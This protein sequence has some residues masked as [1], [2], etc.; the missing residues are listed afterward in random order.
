MSNCNPKNAHPV[1][2]MEHKPSLLNQELNET[3][4]EDI[5]TAPETKG[6]NNKYI[7]IRE[8]PNFLAWFGEWTTPETYEAMRNDID[9][10]GLFNEQGEPK[11][12]TDISGNK[13]LLNKDGVKMPL[14][15]LFDTVTSSEIN[16]VVNSLSGEYIK[17]LTTAGDT[18]PNLQKYANKKLQ[19]TIPLLE[20][21]I[22]NAEADVMDGVHD[23][24]TGIIILDNFER[25]LKKV[26]LLLSDKD[27]NANLIKRMRGNLEKY[28]FRYSEEDTVKE[29]YTDDLDNKEDSPEDHDD[30]VNF[31]TDSTQVSNRAVDDPKILA[32]LS[33]IPEFKEY[34]A[35]PDNQKMERNSMLSTPKYNDQ[36]SMWGLIE[37]YLV[38]IIPARHNTDT[39]S[40]DIYDT[41]VRVLEENAALTKHPELNY[42]A[43]KLKTMEDVYGKDYANSFKIKFA[44]AFYKSTQN[45]IITQ[46]AAEKSYTPGT[47]DTIK[48]KIIDPAVTNSKGAKITNEYISTILNSPKYKDTP[49][50]LEAAKKPLVH[51]LA[52]LEKASVG[53]GIEN[54]EY[55]DLLDQI[56]N[57]A[58]DLN[59][60]MEVLKYYVG[61]Y[62]NAEPN[63]IQ[64]QLHRFLKRPI[65]HANIL[66]HASGVKLKG[67]YE[68]LEEIAYVRYKDDSEESN[69]ILRARLLESG[70]LL[71]RMAEAAA[72][73]R[74]DVTENT[75]MVGGSQQ[76]AYSNVS[77]MQLEV[78]RWKS[79]D[80]SSL[81]HFDKHSLK[82]AQHI[83]TA[84][85]KSDASLE[86]DYLRVHANSEIKTQRDNQPAL[87]KKITAPDAFLDNYAKMFA[88]EDSFHKEITD[89][90]KGT[91]ADQ[92]KVAASLDNYITYVFGA[93]KN[94]LY[95]I[96]GLPNMLHGMDPYDYT[97]KTIKADF[98]DVLKGYM[99]YELAMA[100]NASMLVANY[101]NEQDPDEKRSLLMN[102]L[103]P[104][105]HYDMPKNFDPGTQEL[106]MDDFINA[107]YLKLGI[108]S[109][110]LQDYIKADPGNKALIIDTKMGYPKLINNFG[111][112]SNMN[113]LMEHV[114]NNMNDAIRKN[115]DYLNDIELI[116]R[117][118]EDG[119]RQIMKMFDIE[120][121]HIMGGN[122]QAAIKFILGS[123]MV[124]YELSNIFNGHIA[125]Y[126]QKR[127]DGNI[128]ITDFLKRAPAVA[129]DG[130]YP[131]HRNEGIS[132]EYIDYNGKT[133]EITDRDDKYVAAIVTNIEDIISKHAEL[134]SKGTGKKQDLKHE[135]AD[136]QG[137][138][139]PEHHKDFLSRVYGWEAVDERIHN[140]LMNPKH[141]ITD[142]DIK[143][144]KGS[145]KSG[146]PLKLMHFEVANELHPGEQLA[147]PV[148]IYLKYSLV[149]LYPALV[150]GTQMETVLKQMQHQGVDQLVFQ[151]GSKAS[152]PTPTTVHNV[153]PDGTYGGLK[154]TMNFNPFVISAERLR[155]QSDIPTKM[156]KEDK[157]SMQAIKNILTNIDLN[158]DKKVYF[159]RDLPAMT[160]KEIYDR[161]N[162]VGVDILG[163]QLKTVLGK[164][165]YDKEEGTFNLQKVKQLL[166]NQMDVDTE[167]DLI[168]MMKSDLPMEAVPNFGQRAFPVL[169]QYIQKQAGRIKTNSQ[170]LVQ[171]ANIGYDKLTKKQKSAIYFFDTEKP[172]LAPPLPKT[173][174]NGNILYFNE[175]GASSTKKTKEFNSMRT[176]KAK[177]IIPFSSIF[178]KTGLSYDEFIKLHK[179]GEIDKEVL[180]AL[181]YRIPNQ[182]ISSND[183]FEIV[184]IL[185]PF[186]GDQ[187]IVYHE[188]T[189]K[190]G[191]DF[192]I[193][194]M[195]MALPNFNVKRKITKKYLD[196]IKELKKLRPDFKHTGDF[197]QYKF[198]SGNQI[199]TSLAEVP[200]LKQY[201]SD[202]GVSFKDGRTDAEH[203]IVFIQE[204]FDQMMDLI[205]ENTENG[206]EE[207]YLF[208]KDEHGDE[209]DITPTEL[210]DDVLEAESKRRE[211]IAQEWVEI[212]KTKEEKKARMREMEDYY[213]KEVTAIKYAT[214]GLKGRQNEFIDLL[215]AVLESEAT[216]SDLMAPLDSDMIKDTINKVRYIKTLATEERDEFYKKTEEQQLKLVKDYIDSIQENAMEQMMPVYLTNSRVDSLEAKTLVAIMAN[217]MT[218]LGESQKSGFALDEKLGIKHNDVIANTLDRIY[219]MGKEGNEDF[220]LSKVVS[221][222]MNAAVDAAKDNYI[223]AGNFNSYTANG[224]MM[225]TRLGIPIE[226]VFVI[227][228]ND[229][230]MKMSKE[231]N[232]QKAKTSDFASEYNQNQLDGFTK[233]LLRAIKEN[234]GDLSKVLSKEDFLNNPAEKKEDILGF[235]NLVQT[236]GKEFND[237]VVAM[238]SDSNG[239]GRNI[240]EFLAIKNRIERVRKNSVSGSF[241]KWWT[242]GYSE[243]N[244]KFNPDVTN[245]PNMKI[246]GAMAN[247]T[248]FLMEEMSRTMLMETTDDVIDAV[249]KILDSL[250]RP[251]ETDV[252]TIKLIY[253]YLYPYLLH[254]TG[255]DIYKIDEDRKEYLLKKFPEELLDY[256]NEL[257]ANGESNE[258]LD[259]LMINTG[260]NKN[261]IEF[262]NYKT[263]SVKDKLRF[264]EFFNDFI[265]TAPK[266]GNVSLADKLVHYAFLT[267]GFKSTRFSFNDMI[268]ANYFLNKMH[269][270]KVQKF[271][272]K[273]NTRQDLNF[274][275]KEALTMMAKDHYKNYKIVKKLSNKNKIGVSVFDGHS[276][277]I[278]KEANTK[279]RLEIAPGKYAP[280]FIKKAQKDELLYMYVGKSE[281][282]TELVYRK[283]RKHKE[284]DFK[285]YSYYNLEDKGALHLDSI[286]YESPV[287][288]LYKESPS[289]LN[290]TDFDA[291]KCK[292]TT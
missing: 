162:K 149:A 174:E 277:G 250:G 51:A 78:Q 214:K 116:N 258:F 59:V 249:N 107:N 280:F 53:T 203:P 3:F 82:I 101:M 251:L 208:A 256:R 253:N 202:N 260:K 191:S 5:S 26:R 102:T 196:I 21:Q 70:S 235:W 288:K 23:P 230:V 8:N 155:Q 232:Y 287:K 268:P 64:E 201:M 236:M 247:N 27:L 134:I 229:T 72:V 167:L 135:I 65:E 120:T 185:P 171:V 76:W 234:G 177:V 181:G 123:F 50:N 188:I 184:G 34:D 224:A 118:V 112:S 74:K 126:K 42:I 105:Y 128:E 91:D 96:H 198:Q 146:T 246:M 163:A 269:G 103:I 252:D 109:K 241:E 219:M 98:K 60:P 272:N 69:E 106:G 17:Y 237:S 30:I 160:G 259:Q 67:D 274:D 205:E 286:E 15:N 88:S 216:Y 161:I 138:I 195:Y 217:N 178:A 56:L 68:L 10:M 218:D 2:G 199:L 61:I 200:A 245:N 176:D 39:T 19:A 132:K 193:D 114:Y 255:H 248:L 20:K 197:M 220:K 57:Q 173:D 239:A 292:T 154:D 141:K 66:D 150:N 227:L 1:T 169:S 48:F 282:E 226:D 55:V 204:H 190:T 242:N 129:A 115:H 291:T 159:F 243:E 158:S 189:A 28:N 93:D 284:S 104:G 186:A 110:A 9:S 37:N 131:V 210:I 18:V 25:E 151:S 206:I 140:R 285:T 45:Y 24:E 90:Y 81:D 40:K 143:W 244:R 283:I 11:L 121:N 29:R 6:V 194:K 168:S 83:L 153:N 43:H 113:A 276:Y 157:M 73:F 164:L 100:D 261:L 170:S 266:T 182:A 281:D 264:K 145:N 225:L 273:L 108:F 156:D 222:L 75:Y 49:N 257:R 289:L 31:L 172:D 122:N 231:K 278:V 137:Y 62:N 124:N 16:D 33:S 212:A 165:G 87:H 215:S 85:K 13:Y 211:Y 95:A 86:M 136:A 262:P 275:Y 79:G 52:D 4:P 44:T 254:Q 41:Y 166:L 63:N 147:T 240:P 290:P 127:K 187:A 47:P 92:R 35:D 139:T 148:P 223:I 175:D 133:H 46:V 58:L 213:S 54:D 265:N 22:E 180:T 94:S 130:K 89:N 267:T 77:G 271:I 209:W 183:S 32:F 38:D 152:N 71:R 36:N 119:E 142:E 179:K 14:K 192:D 80:T 238:K 97:N 228:M 84:A 125:F 221:Y 270:P 12:Q 233:N 117:E 111:S 279:K 263:L 144:L 99:Q 207:P 7:Q